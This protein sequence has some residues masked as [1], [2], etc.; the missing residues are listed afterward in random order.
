MTE[1]VERE[2]GIS[3]NAPLG[4]R[5][6][7]LGNKDCRAFF[8]EKLE[9]ML[10]HEDLSLAFNQLTYMLDQI[11]SIPKESSQVPIISGEHWLENSITCRGVDKTLF[12]NGYMKIHLWECENANINK[13]FIN[14][15]TN[16]HQ[17][18]ANFHLK[19]WRDQIFDTENYA[20]IFFRSKHY[21]Q[22]RPYDTDFFRRELSE[23]SESLIKNILVLMSCK[24]CLADAKTGTAHLEGYD[25][26]L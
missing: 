23:A 6:L 2:I 24:T 8:C 26:E 16:T 11:K 12:V 21:F 13:E 10:K 18:S 17:S 22:V 15:G 4:C 5:K 20:H 3:T 7:D 14:F 1:M 9:E 19:E 25:V